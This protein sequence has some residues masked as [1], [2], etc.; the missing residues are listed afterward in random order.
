MAVEKRHQTRPRYRCIHHCR[1]PRRKL[2][3]SQESPRR[4]KET[5]CT[6]TSNLSPLITRRKPLLPR[7]LLPPRKH[8][9]P[10]RPLHRKRLLPPKKPLHPRKQLLPKQRNLPL[11]RNLKRLLLPRKPLLP[12]R[13]PRHSPSSIVVGVDVCSPPLRKS[14][15]LKLQE[16]KSQRNQLQRYFLLHP[17]TL[18][19]STSLTF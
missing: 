5:R 1:R 17:F 14:P 15:N 2:E 12:R 16:Q 11:Q 8:P 4:R 3:T 19:F 10:K 18:P 7:K 6:R 9:P 13:Y